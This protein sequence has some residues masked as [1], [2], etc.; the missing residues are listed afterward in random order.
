MVCIKFRTSID[1]AC[2]LD[3]YA[4]CQC[5]C[6][7]TVWNVLELSV[8]LGDS[9]NSKLFCSYSDLLVGVIRNHLLIPLGFVFILFTF[10]FN[11]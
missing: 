11:I 8:I 7:V 1:F 9:N 5:E 4:N 10:I 2:V 6:F 3:T